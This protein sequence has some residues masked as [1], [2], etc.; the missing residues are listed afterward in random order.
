MTAETGIQMSRRFVAS[1]GLA[2]AA[3][4][5][6]QASVPVAGQTRTRSTAPNDSAPIRAET[7]RATR[8]VD[9]RPNLQGVWSFATATPLQR[10]EEWA[11]KLVLTD[12]EAAAHEAA[13]PSGGCRLHA[14]GESRLADLEAAYNDEWWDW[15][16]KLVGNRTSLIVDPPDGRMPP[17]TPEA[18][19]RIAAGRAAAAAVQRSSADGPE[20]RN[21]FDRCILGFNSGPPMS[22]SAYNNNFQMFQSRDYVV[23]LNE[24]IHDARIV[25]LDGRP[26][27]PAAIRSWK[28]DLRGR[29]EGDT[30]IVETKNL[31]QES[32][33]RNSSADSFRLTERFSRVDSDTLMY[34]YTINDPATWVRPWTV[35]ILMKKGPGDLYEYACHEG[36]YAMTNLLSAAR[37]EERKAA[38]EAARKGLR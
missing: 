32:A 38:E 26:H 9:D 14:C 22:P 23:I 30:L 16:T 11:G 21:L 36:N 1:I 18:Q 29:W 17:L 12:E 25:P 5:L 24:M 3:I 2:F 34:E 15:G 19:K 4:V 8:T 33:Y 6:S 27:V 28:G 20:D 7:L 31:R 35:Q 37:A 10:P 13:L